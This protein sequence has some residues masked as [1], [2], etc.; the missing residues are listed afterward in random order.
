MTDVQI[1]GVTT[2]ALAVML[3]SIVLNDIRTH[4]ISNISVLMVLALGL[5]SQVALNETMGIAYWLSGMAVG[6]AIFIPFYIGGGMG[7]GDVKLMAAV[8]SVLGTG[9][10][11]AA[12]AVALV[13]GLPLAL[14]IVMHRSISE[15]R[16]MQFTAN[17]QH[18]AHQTQGWS[19]KS[20]TREGS[21]QRIPFAA[22]IA[23]GAIGS[24]WWT[25]KLQHL[26]GVL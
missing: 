17:A 26:A 22:A 16:A 23:V 25:G 2:V 1:S 9:G 18:G 21:K 20:F 8:G 12:A 6:F 4:R 24:L 19:T 13:A 14:I 3:V 11:A 15:K 5:G 7:A 10:A